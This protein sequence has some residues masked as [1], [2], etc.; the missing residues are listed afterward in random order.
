MVG[1]DS[2]IST[3]V[4]LKRNHAIAPQREWMEW[5]RDLERY[6]EVHGHCNVPS[7]YEIPENGRKLGSWLTNQ[8]RNKKL[9]NLREDR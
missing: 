6:D 2:L 1:E 9:G 3:F 5:F 4:G 8:R 7:T